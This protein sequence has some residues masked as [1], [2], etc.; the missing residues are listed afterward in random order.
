MIL[1]RTYEG[2]FILNPR[3]EFLKETIADSNVKVVIGSQYSM[4]IIYDFN[5]YIYVLRYKIVLW[6]LITY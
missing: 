2:D 5:E 4:L 6:N 1:W 3:M